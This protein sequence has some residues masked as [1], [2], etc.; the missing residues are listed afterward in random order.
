MNSSLYV[1]NSPFKY[2]KSPSWDGI[3]P[4][5][6]FDD[7]YMSSTHCKKNRSLSMRTV[8]RTS[9]VRQRHPYLGWT[10]SPSRS[11]LCIRNCCR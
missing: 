7:M 3:V 1:E 4:S 11:G 2:F 10:L 5:R 6:R 8:G 9:T